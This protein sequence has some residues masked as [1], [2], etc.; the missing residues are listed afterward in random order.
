MCKEMPV[1]PRGGQE[2]KWR[3]FEEERHNGSPSRDT[4]LSV[5]SFL[6]EHWHTENV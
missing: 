5:V 3:A 4:I 2:K 1:I 6:P